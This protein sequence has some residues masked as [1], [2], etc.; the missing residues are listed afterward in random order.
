MTAT[1][2]HQNH[3]IHDIRFPTCD[4]TSRVYDISSLYMW[5]HSHYVCEHMS[6]TFNIKH[7]VLSQSNCYKGNHNLISVSVWSQRLYRWYNTH[8]IYDM[9]P[10]IFMAQY[11]LYMTSHPWFMTSQ[12]SIRYISLLYLLSNWL[13]FTA[14][15][16]YL[17]HHSQITE[18]ITLIV[19]MITQVKYAWHHMNTYDIKYTL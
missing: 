12:L 9:A 5:H 7:R 4:I 16:L 11:A 6:T 3:C 8:C 18:N 2:C 10:T 19:C 17:C 1:V 13:Y 14:H 15:P